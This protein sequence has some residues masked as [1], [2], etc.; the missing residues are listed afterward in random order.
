MTVTE[1]PLFG[2]VEIKRL[3]DVWEPAE[4][5]WCK[6]PSFETNTTGWAQAT[7]AASTISR[8]T[9]QFHSGTAS[10]QV[11]TTGATPNQG[12]MYSPAVTTI[13]AG[14]PF[15]V[16][17]WVLMPAGQSFEVAAFSAGTGYVD[18]KVTYTGTGS[19]QLVKAENGIVGASQNPYLMVRTKTAVALTFYVDDALIIAAP[20]AGL[21]FDGSSLPILRTNMVTSPS[22][23]GGSVPPGWTLSSGTVSGGWVC[24]TSPGSTVPY[25][26]TAR[27]GEAI[28][29]GDVIYGQ[30]QIQTDSANIAYL[31]V[32]IHQR[33][34]NT[35]F[36]TGNAQ[37]IVPVTVGVPVTVDLSWTAS[38]AVPANDLDISVVP[39]N[40]SGVLFAPA[41]GS[42]FKARG[43]IL[44][45]KAGDYFD[46]YSTKAG[47]AYGW[48]GT[49]NASASIE[50][51]AN[52]NTRY[53]WT[54]TPHAST[55]RRE[56]RRTDFIKNATKLSIR[57]GGTRT[58]IG[59]KTDV[60]I[61]S[62]T[63]F[64]DEDPM[65]GGT[66]DIG[67]TIQIVNQSSGSEPIFT[68]R[69][70]DITS[71]YPLVKTTGE[72][73]TTVIVTV[74]DAVQ[75]HATT[76]RYGAMI[77]APF[78]ETF[79]QRATRYAGSSLAP[80]EPPAVGAPKVVYAF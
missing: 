21:P 14:S 31:R 74:S 29:L 41:A 32:N 61:A 15:S 57:R 7:G 79:E 60:G 36:T 80:I 3:T 45:R 23:A 6:N 37:K 12:A 55:S 77:G 33:S 5:N 17:A 59:T 62:F 4:V 39:C 44:S 26:F 50:T 13:P 28:A 34:N 52:S 76:P 72:E 46:G 47:F 22:A 73:R 69:I 53:A 10:L 27:A 75:I 43:P 20:I 63:L 48:T 11:V 58:G 8:A 51:E 40:A 2:Q 30:I 71:G 67:Q 42:V 68:G 64:N 16:A 70:T 56:T 78:Y 25:I 18:Q 38:A 49:A 1:R 35:Y 65:Q 24:A 9:A 66:L 19:W 54:G